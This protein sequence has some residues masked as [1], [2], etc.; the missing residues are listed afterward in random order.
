MENLVA[1][2][3]SELEVD[4]CE[5]LHDL[6]AEGSLNMFGAA[7]HVAAMF[8]LDNK[9][10]KRLLVLWMNSFNEAGDYELVNDKPCS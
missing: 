7:P 4:V 8:G 6:R 1:R 9:E 5:F 3:A 10:G 2:K